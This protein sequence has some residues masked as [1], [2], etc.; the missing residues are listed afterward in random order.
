MLVV[1]F[2]FLLLSIWFELGSANR[3]RVCLQF[4]TLTHMTIGVAMCV[5]V[6]ASRCAQR[7]EECRKIQ[8]LIWL[9]IYLNVNTVVHSILDGKWAEMLPRIALRS[10]RLLLNFTR[11]QPCGRI[12]AN[13]WFDDSW[14]CIFRNTRCSVVKMQFACI[15]YL[16]FLCFHTGSLITR[17]AKAKNHLQISMT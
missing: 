14:R 11:R 8:Y 2:C 7:R 6:W 4:V 15:F 17:W 3:T 9:G 1:I 12:F 16:S 5:N 13:I 10:Y